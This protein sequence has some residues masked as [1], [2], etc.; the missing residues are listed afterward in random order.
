MFDN[1]HILKDAG[2]VTSS[3][4]AEVDASAKVVN[5][6]S[7]LMRMNLIIDISAL[8]ISS[9]DELYC[10]HLMGGSDASFTQ[11]VSLASKELGHNASLQGN[12]DSKISRIILPV[13]NEQGGT[14]FPY[15]RIRHVISGT[16]PSINYIARIEDDLP[17]T[18]WT[19]FETTTT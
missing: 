7:G 4:Y 2:A 14:V 3:G 19:T 1:T 17:F 12:R 9:D 6:G 11:Q 18:G 15:V 13:Q 8:D 5:L 16:S 10:I